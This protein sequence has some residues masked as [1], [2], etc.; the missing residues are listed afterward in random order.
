MNEAGF[1]AL[2]GLESRSKAYKHPET[3][4]DVEAEQTRNKFN[5]G[6]V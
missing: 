5:H 1:R 6:E 3:G 4:N 2:D